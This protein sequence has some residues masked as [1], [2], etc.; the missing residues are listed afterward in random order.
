[1]N[2]CH[3]SARWEED[4]KMRKTSLTCKKKQKG[5]GIYI[6]KTI[7]FSIQHSI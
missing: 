2:T 5:R 1:M 3:Y 6:A 4:N 7:D